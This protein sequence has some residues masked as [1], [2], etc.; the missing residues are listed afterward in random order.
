M[1]N[2]NQWVIKNSKTFAANLRKLTKVFDLTIRS[3]RNT[4]DHS[5]FYYYLSSREYNVLRRQGMY[6]CISTKST[7]NIF[8]LK[9]D[10]LSL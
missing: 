4:E 2:H 9:Y 3:C 1:L 5:P 8:Y 10:T 6:Q 7:K